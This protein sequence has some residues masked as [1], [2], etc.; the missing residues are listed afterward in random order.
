[1]KLIPYLLLLTS[2]VSCVPPG[3]G[4]TIPEENCQW[5]YNFTTKEWT[6]ECTWYYYS[7]AGETLEIDLAQS[8]ADKEE[9]SQIALAS[10]YEAQFDLTSKSA[11]RIAKVVMDLNSLEERTQEDLL[12]FAQKLYGVNPDEIISAISNAQVGN[13]NELEIVIE[14]ASENFGTS[15]ETTKA[16]IQELHGQAL[17]E[18]G[19]DI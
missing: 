11:M 15:K 19:I 12:D 17:E 2:L 13:N 3:P 16:I 10:A 7:Q 18:N 6:R 14:K 9:A 5:V 4:P 1:M 8:V